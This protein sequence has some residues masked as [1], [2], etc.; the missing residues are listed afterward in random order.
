MVDRGLRKAQA[1]ADWR[2]R[3]KLRPDGRVR[4]DCMRGIALAGLGALAVL[5]ALLALPTI[6][7]ALSQPVSLLL[8]LALVVPGTVLG[9]AAGGAAAY[10]YAARRFDER[11]LRLQQQTARGLGPKL[12]RRIGQQLGLQIGE[13]LGLQIGEEL[14]Q[15]LAIA[16][17]AGAQRMASSLPDAAGDAP[18]WRGT[19]SAHPASKPGHPAPARAVYEFVQ[20][21]SGDEESGDE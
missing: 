16:R 17:Q 3:Q 18:A 1:T 10:W 13:E 15:R 8:A 19:R 14:S 9:L 6:L 12:G 2:S 7:A 11:L 5:A 4:G 21:F 20:M